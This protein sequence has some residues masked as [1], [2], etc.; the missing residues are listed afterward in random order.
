MKSDL[1]RPARPDL[2]RCISFL[3]AVID[4]FL[5]PD[6]L[7]RMYAVVIDQ[8]HSLPPSLSDQQ[9]IVRTDI[10]MQEAGIMKAF[11]DLQ[12]ALDTPDMDGKILLLSRPFG[13]FPVH[14]APAGKSEDGI[15][16]VI[17]FK[18]VDVGIYFTGIVL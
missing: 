8:S 15:Q 7:Q 3:G 12:C 2:R 4:G 10:Q 17:Q 14:A 9:N 18:C 6:L 16:C 11:Q 5:R 13:Q 1:L